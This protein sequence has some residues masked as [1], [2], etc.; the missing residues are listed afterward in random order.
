LL[1]IFIF[2]LLFSEDGSSASSKQF[3][4][5]LFS[6]NR[7]QWIKKFKSLVLEF[8]IEP[9][10][11]WN[12]FINAPYY[13]N[14][15]LRSHTWPTPCWKLQFAFQWR[16]LPTG[17][18]YFLALSLSLWSCHMLWTFSFCAGQPSSTD[19]LCGKCALSSL[20]RNICVIFFFFLS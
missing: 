17:E 14:L 3:S 5:T 9:E 16:Q 19:L 11:T 12:L 10:S 8:Y 6:Q 20:V 15:F 13:T 18:K 2:P 7:K 1:Y 4:N